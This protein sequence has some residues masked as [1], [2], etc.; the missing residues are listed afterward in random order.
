MEISFSHAPNKDESVGRFKLA[1][2]DKDP[3]RQ[4]RVVRAHGLKRNAKAPC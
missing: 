2:T 4:L 1:H 3:R